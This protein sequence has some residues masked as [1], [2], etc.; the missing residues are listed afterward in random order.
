MNKEAGFIPGLFLC[1]SIMILHL[2]GWHFFSDL[3]DSLRPGG[4]R[5]IQDLDR[6]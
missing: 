1:K 2:L 3:G 4:R 6:P 5:T